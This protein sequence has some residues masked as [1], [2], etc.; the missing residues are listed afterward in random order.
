MSDNLLLVQLYALRA[1][2]D[3][4]ILAA[5]QQLVTSQEQTVE[6][7]GCPKCGA[8][9]DKVHMHKM[10]DRSTRLS[11]AACGSEWVNRAGHDEPALH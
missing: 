11:C 8:S 2:L 1:Q 3:A 5:E 9:S 4:T 10:L 7:G 6:L